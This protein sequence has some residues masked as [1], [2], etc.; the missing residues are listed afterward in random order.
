[1]LSG[2]VWGG[3]ENSEVGDR[4]S[5]SGLE[6]SNRFRLWLWWWLGEQPTSIFRPNSKINP[7]QNKTHNKQPTQ[8]RFVA[9]DLAPIQTQA[10][11]YSLLISGSASLESPLPPPPPTSSHS[12]ALCYTCGPKAYTCQPGVC[13][14]VNASPAGS[15]WSGSPRR[16]ASRF[17]WNGAGTR[18]WLFYVGYWQTRKPPWHQWGVDPNDGVY[19]RVPIFIE[20]RRF[21]S[22]GEWTRWE[23]SV[24][25]EIIH[26]GTEMRD[27]EHVQMRETKRVLRWER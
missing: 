4:G 22:C 6:N 8:I 21:D 16:A 14:A 24:Q 25:G 12:Y 19:L 5:R 9:F 1:M 20:F 17:A 11:S 15:H 26:C 2:W 7:N 18:S 23:S 27:G 10:R 13:R 3:S